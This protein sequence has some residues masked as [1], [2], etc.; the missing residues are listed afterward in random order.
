ML[1]EKNKKEIFTEKKMGTSERQTSSLASLNNQNKKPEIIIYTMP[2]RF[3]GAA[4]DGEHKA[5]GIGLIIIVSGAIILIVGFIFIYFYFTKFNKEFSSVK[6]NIPKPAEISTTTPE[7]TKRLTEDKVENDKNIL[8]ASEK[9]TVKNKKS[10][11]RIKVATSTIY[12]STSPTATQIIRSDEKKASGTTATSTGL[13]IFQSAPDTDNDSLTDAEEA[14]LGTNLDLAD[15]DGDGYKDG[16]ELA[17]LYN[18]TGPGKII[19]NLRIKKYT[20]NI[21][22]YS[23]YYPTRWPTETLGGLNSIMFKIDKEQ[24]I[25]IIAEQNPENKSVVEWYKAET[26]LNFIKPEQKI[27]KAGWKGVRSEDGLTVYLQNSASDYIFVLTYNIG[28]ETVLSYGHIFQMMV[29]S[30]SL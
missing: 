21:Y 9:S 26:G 15:T 24:F 2:K 23:L 4:G 30:F 18:P 27:Y 5:R 17:H 12:A 25:Q 7:K 10:I 11:K 6:I 13:K 3:L 14:L 8:S 1:G 22:N 28:L 19:T 20:N 16:D 29:N